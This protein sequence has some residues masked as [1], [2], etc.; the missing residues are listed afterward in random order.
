MMGRKGSRRS[1]DIHYYGGRGWRGRSF[2][3]HSRPTSTGT[4]EPST[5]LLSPCPC[6]SLFHPTTISIISDRWLRAETRLP[7]SFK[8]L[9]LPEKFP[10]PTPLTD[11]Q[12]LPIPV[13]HSKEFEVIYS[14]TFKRSTRSKL[15]CSKRCIQRTRMFSSV[16]RP[17]AARRY[18]WSSRCSDYGAAFEQPRAVC[19]EPYQ[20]MVNQHVAEWGEKFKG[21][22]GG[23]RIVSLTGETSTD[24]RLLEEGD[25]VVC[26]P[27]QVRCR[28]T[29]VQSR[30]NSALLSGTFYQG[31]GASE[32]TFKPPA[33]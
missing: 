5:M 13:L 9:I 22:Q 1:G 23:K 17:A 30:A 3:R 18:V 2:Q 10:L 11:L 32:R 15:R 14:K 33:F 4:L 7:I 21:L 27:M 12:P 19:I 29:L 6:S 25:V 26:R 24:S 16:H 28:T 20:E 31:D 8:Y